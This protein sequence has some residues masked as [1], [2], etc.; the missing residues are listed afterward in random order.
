MQ[1]D[2][3]CACAGTGGPACTS[4]CCSLGQSVFEGACQSFASAFENDADTA[5][6]ESND[7]F[8]QRVNNAPQPSS[9]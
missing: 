9:G 4:G 1:V 6:N 3:C 2:L 8:Q 5:L 7:V